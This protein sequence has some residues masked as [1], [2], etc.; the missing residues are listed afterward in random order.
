MHPCVVVFG[1]FSP[2]F[3][4]FQVAGVRTIDFTHKITPKW[5]ISGRK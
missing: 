2:F 1:E 3:C 5:V 4:G